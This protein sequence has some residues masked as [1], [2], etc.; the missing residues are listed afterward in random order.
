[1]SQKYVEIANLC[2]RSFFSKMRKGKDEYNE[3]WNGFKKCVKCKM[4]M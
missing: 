4:C 2:D 1:M 3:I